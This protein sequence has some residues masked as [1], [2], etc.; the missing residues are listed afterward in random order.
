VS[1]V[2]SAGVAEHLSPLPALT[3]INA[4]RFAAVA[5]LVALAFVPAIATVAGAAGTNDRVESTEQAVD[6]AAERWFTAQNAAAEID[7][8]I[9]DIEDRRRDA[10]ARVDK[11]RTVARDRA[12]LL[13]KT[14]D[15]GLVLLG[16]NG[17]SALEAARR[18]K[19]ASQANA[20]NEEVIGD[21]TAALDDL[22]AQ[23]R[24]LESQRAEQ[25]KVLEH[26]GSERD[27]LEEQLS[28]LRAEAQR[29]AEAALKAARTQQARERE[30][31]RIQT[32][33]A[34][35]ATG[36]AANQIAPP[37]APVPVAPPVTYQVP[38]VTSGRTSAHHND[39]FLVC[40]RMRESGG[41]Y[42]INTGNG[43]YGAYQF[44]P[45]TWDTTASHA[46]RRDLIG[47]LPSSASPYDQDELAWSLYQW[48][49]KGPWGGRC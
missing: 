30:A 46:G 20:E 37:T 17:S 32:L 16:D 6:D 47:V 40:T 1:V 45:S 12:V 13:Y 43:Y 38:P 34:S 33:S 42:A 9:A 48:Q 22:D 7:A 8:R 21:L 18:E 3:R 44:L 5:I 15:L 2:R 24:E 25:A 36:P 35:D 19:L 23:H 28:A 49:G 27:A 39:P 31:A 29:E 11:L 26:V 41:N 10:Q 14:R 4:T